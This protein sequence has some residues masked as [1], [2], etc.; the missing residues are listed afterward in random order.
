MSNNTEQLEL[1]RGLKSRHI[2]MIS[3][4]GT[5][6]TGLLLA[7][8]NSIAQAGPGGALLAYALI[9][10]MVYFLMTGLGEMSAYMPVSSTSTYATRFIDPSLGFALGWN[11]WYNWAVTIAAEVAAVAL[12][13]KYWF[14]DTPSYIWSAA[15][16]IIIFLLNYL[17][18]NTFGESEYWFAFIKVA[19]IIIFLIVSFLMIFGIIGGKAPVGFTNFFEGDGPFHGGFFAILGIFLAAGFSFQGTEFYYSIF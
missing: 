2:T 5:I 16:L 3:L 11:Y 6:G 15:F 18:V 10:V 8:G 14:P 4:G 19:T 12:V 13:M 9:G 7:S 1:S 17:S